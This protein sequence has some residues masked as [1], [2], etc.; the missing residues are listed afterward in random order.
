MEPVLESIGARANSMKAS[1]RHEWEL[2]KIALTG[3][4][5]QPTRPVVKAKSAAPTRKEK[6]E[7]S[8][9]GGTSR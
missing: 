6:E 9:C 3:R 8:D 7:A 4:L 5:H 1:T 2:S